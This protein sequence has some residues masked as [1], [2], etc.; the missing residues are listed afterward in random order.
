MLA[1]PGKTSLS[2]VIPTLCSN[3][4]SNPFVG[5]PR[6]K[7]IITIKFDK[8][9]DTWSIDSFNAFRRL[10]KNVNS[11]FGELIGEGANK[12]VWNQALE[13]AGASRDDETVLDDAEVD[14]LNIRD[15]NFTDYDLSLESNERTRMDNEPPRREPKATTKATIKYGTRKPSCVVFCAYAY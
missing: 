3:T 5:E 8:D 12:T 7:G 2:Q 6:G 4:S 1:G 10:C 11:N 13:S 9:H 14:S 15:E